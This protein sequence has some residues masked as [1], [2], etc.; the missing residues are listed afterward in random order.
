MDDKLCVTLSLNICNILTNPGKT[1]F[2]FQQL[3]DVILCVAFSLNM[4]YILTKTQ[5]NAFSF[6]HQTDARPCVAFSL[7]NCIIF[8]N[9]TKNDCLFFFFQI[10]CRIFIKYLKYNYLFSQHLKNVRL[11]D[12]FSLNTGQHFNKKDNE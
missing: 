2:S 9:T 3:T 10:S 7:N 8:T 11:C 12:E 4:C 5:N 6:Q 1:V